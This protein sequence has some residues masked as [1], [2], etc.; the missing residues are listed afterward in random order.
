M[1]MAGA[2]KESACKRVEELTLTPASQKEPLHFPFQILERSIEDRSARVHHNPPSSA[3]LFQAKPNRFA[4]PPLDSVPADASSD[5]PGYRE[6]NFRSLTL[7]RV[8]AEGGEERT[9][10]AGTPIIH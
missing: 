3:K 5:R 10:D 4:H 2:E 8:Q 9:G 6:T 7:V 1:R